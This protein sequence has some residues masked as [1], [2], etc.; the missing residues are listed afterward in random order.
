MILPG[1]IR[2]CWI[3]LYLKTARKSGAQGGRGDNEGQTG[4]GRPWNESVEI[5]QLVLE[6]VYVDVLEKRLVEVV[7]KD[8]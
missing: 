6:V 5:N 1:L 2:V 4:L 3:H 8:D 7:P